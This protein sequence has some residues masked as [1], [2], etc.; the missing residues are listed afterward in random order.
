MLIMMSQLSTWKHWHG[1]STVFSGCSIVSQIH[2]NNHNR[3][4]L[5]HATFC[6]AWLISFS[7]STLGYIVPS[8]WWKK[9]NNTVDQF[10]EMLCLGSQRSWK[11]A[12]GFTLL[13][14]GLGVRSENI[15]S[16]KVEHMFGPLRIHR[17]KTM[18]GAAQTVVF[19]FLMNEW[20]LAI[21][22]LVL[23]P[24]KYHLM[25]EL[26]NTANKHQMICIRY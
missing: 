12:S 10:C 1:S 2:R 3:H 21:I 8:V 4:G 11:T 17:N 14:L 6:R 20:I 9:K 19:F 25:D 18:S 26:L 22:H 23:L 24:S 7:Y 16:S 5:L 13:F 15:R